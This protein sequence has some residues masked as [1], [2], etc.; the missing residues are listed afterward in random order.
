VEDLSVYKNILNYLSNNHLPTNKC[1]TSSEYR[2]LKLREF[3]RIAT[4]LTCEM[5]HLPSRYIHYYSAL[6]LFIL[7]NPPAGPDG[8]WRWERDDSMQSRGDAEKLGSSLRVSA[9]PRETN[10]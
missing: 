2:G 10:P 1:R 7:V 6:S 9:A 8:M 5:Q 3:R 4:P